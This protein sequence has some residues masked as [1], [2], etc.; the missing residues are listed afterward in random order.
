MSDL[1]KRFQ[2]FGGIGQV[3]ESPNTQPGKRQNVLH[4][5][6]NLGV[7]AAHDETVQLED[8]RCNLVGYQR[9]VLGSALLMKEETEGTSPTA[10]S[11]NARGTLSAARR[12]DTVEGYFALLFPRMSGTHTRLS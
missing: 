12:Q 9:L 11:D 10:D 6:S 7:L 4:L 1:A 2:A 8:M 3:F 5:L